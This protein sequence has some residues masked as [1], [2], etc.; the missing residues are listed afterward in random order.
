MKARLNL[1]I[2]AELLEKVKQYAAAKHNS[3]S[4]LVEAYFRSALRPAVP[5]RSIINLIE[6]LPQPEIA[7]E[8]DP[9]QRYFEENAAKYGF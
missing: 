8:G 2:D 9:T 4:E 6:S 5:E 3:V 7:P 1:T